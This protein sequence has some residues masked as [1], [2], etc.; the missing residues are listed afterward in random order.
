MEFKIFYDNEP[1]TQEQHDEIDEIVVEQEIDR[2][3]EARIKIP[4]SMSEEGAWEGEDEPA[5]QSFTRVRI[6]ARIG[7]DGDFVALIDGQI[8]ASHND[9][10]PTPDESNLTLVVHDDS[11]LLHREEEIKRYDGASASEIAQEIFDTAALGGTPDVEESPVFPDNPAEAIIQ[12]GTK[13]QILRSLARR[14]GDFFAYVLPGEN[15]GESIGCFKKIPTQPDESLPALVM[16]GEDANISEFKVKESARKPAE[17]QAATLSLR[18]KSV[19]TG[20]FNYLDA[21]LLGDEAAT[22]ASDE[23]VSKKR[24][25][26]GQN[27]SVDLEGAIAGEA[28]RSG[29]SLEA[30]GSV[31]PDVYAGI[32]S[33]YRVVPV[34]L[35]DSRFSTNYVIC[36]VVHTISQSEYT[37]S[38]SVKGNSVSAAG[39][40]L[41]GG[42]F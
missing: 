28:T 5:N 31:L 17:F 36:K 32:L 14:H 41:G 24:L 9:R 25:P 27:D 4:V 34:R 6:E 7:E 42:I 16:F 11:A 1:A 22:N 35:S 37:Q 12:R 3:W 21:E 40:G 30:S 33:P 38:F 26:P 29:Y 10:S 15:A 8:V 2:V 20:T 13:M 39:G 19:T 18:D 23:N